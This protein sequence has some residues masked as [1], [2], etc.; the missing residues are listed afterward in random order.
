MG[1]VDEDT[2]HQIKDINRKMLKTTGYEYDERNLFENKLWYIKDTGAAGGT[3]D[4]TIEMNN[5]TATTFPNYYLCQE[6]NGTT[7]IGYFYDS[8]E[9]EGTMYASLATRTRERR[10]WIR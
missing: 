4:V 3:I 5:M 8:T 10:R 6:K 7:P 2:V 1:T 9:L